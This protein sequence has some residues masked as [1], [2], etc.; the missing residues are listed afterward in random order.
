MRVIV[1][2]DNMERVKGFRTALMNHSVHYAY[3]IEDA[4]KLLESIKFD[5]GFFDHDI[6][7]SLLTGYT[8]VNWVKNHNIS[9][10]LVY[11][12]FNPVGYDNMNAVIPGSH[13][14]NCWLLDCYGMN[15]LIENVA[16]E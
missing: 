2:E 7:G 13:E 11:H 1:V 4:I 10:P 6:E 16:Q 14:P 5:I 8:L 9:L 15:A 12:T 3:N